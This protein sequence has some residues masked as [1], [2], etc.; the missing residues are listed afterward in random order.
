M[1]YACK[2]RGVIYIL[3]LRTWIMLMH[4]ENSISGSDSVINVL[5]NYAA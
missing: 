2:I 3:K 5:E 1:S 4:L